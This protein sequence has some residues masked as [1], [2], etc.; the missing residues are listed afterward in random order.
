MPPPPPL[1]TPPPNQNDHR[2]KKRNLQQ[3]KSGRAIFGAPLLGPIPPLPFPPFLCSSSLPL[4]PPSSLLI[5]RPSQDDIKIFDVSMSS[6]QV[7]EE[8]ALQAGPAPVSS[9][10]LDGTDGAMVGGPAI[11]PDRDGELSALF[12]DGY[13]GQYVSLGTEPGSPTFT[14]MLWASFAAFGPDVQAL[15][16]NS[17]PGMSCRILGRGQG[18]AECLA[19]RTGGCGAT[20]RR[21]VT[22]GVRGR[23]A[24]EQKKCKE[25]PPP[26]PGSNPFQVT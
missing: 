23:H 1:W 25:E 7:K 12:L 20:T 21:N 24:F 22:Q 2:G 10:S 26:P 6:Q 9:W 15:A 18:C 16:C 5:H 8:A 17:A 14:V 3:G 11:I 19:Y 4:P 13:R